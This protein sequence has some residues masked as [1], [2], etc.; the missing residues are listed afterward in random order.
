MMMIERRWVSDFLFYFL[1]AAYTVLGFVTF[2]GNVEA[3]NQKVPS[4]LTFG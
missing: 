4:F 2:F 3:K 1:L